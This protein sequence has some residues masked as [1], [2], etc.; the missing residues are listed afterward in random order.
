MLLQ[1]IAYGTGLLCVH[2]IMP[3]TKHGIRNSICAIC[4]AVVLGIMIS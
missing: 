3:N 2:Y 1:I 4:I